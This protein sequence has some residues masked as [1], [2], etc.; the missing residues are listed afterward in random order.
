MW[1]L[2]IN[3]VCLRLRNDRILRYDEPGIAYL[4][5]DDT[6]FGDAAL[7]QL[8]VHPGQCQ[9]TYWQRM[10]EDATGSRTKKIGKYS[11]LVYNQINAIFADNPIQNSDSGWVIVPSDFDSN[12]VGLLYGIL[13]YKG[14]QPRGFVD[15]AVVASSQSL[16]TTHATYYVDLHLQ[17]TVVTQLTT[18]GREIDA[19]AVKT[20]PT[21]G[22][23]QLVK[24]WLDAV[25][26]RS[27][28]EMR[29]DPRVV[30]TTEQ[31][32]FER[33]RERLNTNE[34][35]ISIEHNGETRS[36]SLLQDELAASSVDIYDR[37]VAEC[38]AGAH[39]LLSEH[40]N[41]M[42]GFFEFINDSGR[43]AEVCQ[44][45]SIVSAT[46]N[47]DKYVRADADADLHKSYV[48][49]P[50]V[51]A[52]EDAG[53]SE[54]LPNLATN[55]PTHVLFGHVAH[56]IGTSR[57]LKFEETTLCSLNLENGHV[58]L[59][60]HKG[61]RVNVNGAVVNART[62]VTSGDRIELRSNTQSGK[63]IVLISVADG[64]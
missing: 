17:R 14:L 42:P 3:D 56:P 21:A 47:M 37:I 9:S 63:E 26:H 64:G 33:L 36:V 22:Y 12:Q 59:T 2:E 27:M 44:A 50:K 10:N 29:F 15:V 48:I 62:Q 58:M 11:D 13:D 1:S 53:A 24:R 19:V 40:A 30:G 57:D 49:K 25:A 54:P 31:Q 4:T 34:L 45:E 6:V 5:H 46:A 28:D 61:S 20:V 32:V 8:F 41:Y 60:P 23:L 16:L 52:E 35:V 7:S 38:D 51:E 39:I 18:N 55:T 43:S